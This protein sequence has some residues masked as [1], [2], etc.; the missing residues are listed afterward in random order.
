M[1]LDFLFEPQ[2]L[3][4]DSTDATDP[5]YYLRKRYGNSDVVVF[6]AGF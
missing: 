6:L 5:D 2:D 1:N 3:C 4:V